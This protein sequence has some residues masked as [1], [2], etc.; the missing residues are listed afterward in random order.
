MQDAWKGAQDDTVR[1]YLV[2]LEVNSGLIS[3]P[4]RWISLDRFIG[5][6]AHGVGNRDAELVGCLEANAGWSFTG[7]SP[8]SAVR[9]NG[10]LRIC[11]CIEYVNF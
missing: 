1:R 3:R 10:H 6:E 4:R 8:G 2:V 5:A 11:L 9:Y 7:R